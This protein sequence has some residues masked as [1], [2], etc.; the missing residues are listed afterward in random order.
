MKILPVIFAMIT[1]ITSTSAAESP[2]QTEI[3]FYVGTYTKQ[4]SESK[5]IYRGVLNTST[6]AAR[7]SG[8]V[9]AAKNPTFL[10]V[11]PGGKFLYAAIEQDG[12]AVGAWAIEKDGS[13][14]LLDTQ[15]TR[16]KG[17]CHVW[18]DAS[19]RNVLAAS[20]GS[21]TLACVPIEAEGTLGEPTTLIHHTGK[22]PNPLRQ[23]EPH[24]HSI[25]TNGAFAYACDLGTDDVFIY[26]FDAAKGTL[27]PHNPPSAKV[28]P[29]SGPRHLA[30]HPKG[31][32]AYVCNEMASTVT[33]FAHDAAKGTLAPLQ[34]LST[35][36]AGAPDAGENSTAEIF[37]HPN[38]KFV[39]VSNR[40]HDSIAISTIGADGKLTFN[41]AAPAHVKNPRG[42][43]LT[44]D[45]RWLVVGGQD[46]ANLA[47][48][49]VDAT[50]G[51][52]TFTSEITGIAMPVSVEFVK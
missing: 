44:P 34:T 24:A 21:A 35:L 22:G 16:E 40:G 32:F 5:G 17:N 46:S 30:F 52:L 42:F 25:Y 7:I 43:N 10:A 37:C 13:L 4:P 1:A 49:K 9:A 51:S 11:H 50:T 3:P 29:G 15:S 38:G 45:G 36:P 28:P 18:V 19:G 23:N 39:Y 26:Q 27:T 47:I 6:G 14:R 12:G 2:A 48:H 33:T 20:Y 8:L 31:G 41:E